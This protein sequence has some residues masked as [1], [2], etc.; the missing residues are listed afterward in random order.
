MS[1]DAVNLLGIRVTIASEKIILEDLQKYLAS[2]PQNHGKLAIIV[3]PNPEQIVLAQADTHF[4][5][6]LNNADVALPDG[7]GVVWAARKLRITNSGLPMQ[8]ISGVDFMEK[9]VALAAVNSVPIG[10]IGGK[11]E[12][13]LEALQCLQQQ[14]PRLNGWAEDGPQFQILNSKLRISNG[15]DFDDYVR[16]LAQRIKQSKTKMVFVGLGAPRQEYFIDALSR[17][18]EGAIVILMSVGGA[19]SLISGRIPRAPATVRRLGLEWFWRL[20]AE[21]W[22]W[23]R[24]L[25]LLKFV[26][27][28]LGA[29]PH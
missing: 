10:L 12:L 27:L 18:L 7:I 13:A 21:P 23:R 29:K 15:G 17:H 9:M 24:Q 22:R 28:V 6:I 16:H 2:G 26:L 19:F 1:L 4:R 11:N 20:L 8:R 3:T 25:S 14:H 5:N